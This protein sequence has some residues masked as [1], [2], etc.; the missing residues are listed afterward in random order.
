MFWGT[1]GLSSET[2]C[3]TAAA[4]GLEAR[5]HSHDETAEIAKNVGCTDQQ[6][7]FPVVDLR[8]VQLELLAQLGHGL[9]LTQCRQRHLGLK[10]KTVRTAAAPP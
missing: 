9:V 2:V 8:R 10:R 7:P 3:T 4:T 1:S 5:K 6:L